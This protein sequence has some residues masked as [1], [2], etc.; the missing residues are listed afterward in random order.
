MLGSLVLLHIQQIL[1]G[2]RI[3]IMSSNSLLQ[4]LLRLM[5]KARIHDVATIHFDSGLHVVSI[6][7]LFDLLLIVFKL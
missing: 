5:N 3:H 4:H 2:H 6:S 1:H 7:R